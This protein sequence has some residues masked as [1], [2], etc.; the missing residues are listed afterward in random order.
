MTGA[1]AI[2]STV[3]DLL[4]FHQSFM[5]ALSD[6]AER[7][8]TETPGS[9][10]NNLVMTTAPKIKT[11]ESPSLKS[12]AFDWFR[13]PLPG[14]L[15]VPILDNDALVREYPTFGQDVQDLPEILFHAAALLGFL[16]SVIL[17][18]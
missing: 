2:K 14:N 13:T 6:Q 3:E 1:A 12:Y 4:K 17:V 9:P 5:N 10:F 16:G 11:E 18:P 7:N 15:S 8:A